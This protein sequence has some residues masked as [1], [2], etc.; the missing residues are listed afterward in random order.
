MP[1]TNITF[2][3]HIFLFEEINYHACGSQLFYSND[4]PVILL[5][6]KSIDNRNNDDI[7][8]EDFETFLIP[9]GLGVNIDAF[10]W[11]APPILPNYDKKNVVK[12]KQSKVHSKIYYN[13]LTEHNTLLY[14]Q[15]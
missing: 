1:E 3:N 2:N 11:H 15:V 7:L 8:P 12:T 9:A 4:N 13:P 5:L 10:V 6:A 14:I